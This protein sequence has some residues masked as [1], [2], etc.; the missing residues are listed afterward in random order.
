MKAN[1]ANELLAVQDD[2][3]KTIETLAQLQ[4]NKTEQENELEELTECYKKLSVMLEQKGYSRKRRE[5]TSTTWETINSSKCSARHRRRTESK[6]ILEYVHGGEQGSLYGAWDFLQSHCGSDLME[7]FILSFK[8][9]K[10]LEKL[11]G[12]FTSVLEK[13]EGTLKKAVAKKYYGFLSRRKFA[14]LCKIQKSSFSEDGRQHSGTYVQ[15]GECNLSMRSVTVTHKAVDAF[16]K[17]LDIGQIH[18][19]PGYSGAS[20]TV[21][22]LITP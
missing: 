15:Y 10:F 19:L 16:V 9:G 12:K 11:Y 21:S 17:S 13:S 20:R 5:N 4:K 3:D 22:A 14:M 1:F 6:N 7:K 18:Q 2:V 8:R